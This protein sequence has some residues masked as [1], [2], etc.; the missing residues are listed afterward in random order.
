MGLK[1][2]AAGLLAAGCSTLLPAATLRVMTCNVRLPSKND[3]PNVWENRR[4][5]LVAAIRAKDPDLLGTQE[6]FQHQGDYIAAQAPEYSWFGLSRRGNHEDEHMGVF[7]K[8][9]KLRLLESGNFWLSETPETPGSMSW[10]VS[11][12]RMATWGLFEVRA[13][14]RRFY[15]YNTHFA[16]RRED[17]KARTLSARTIADRIAALP[18]NI[19]VVLTGDFNTGA[20]SEAYR[21]F[22]PLL[23]EVWAAAP[24]R[25]GPADTFH[26]FTGKPRPGRI[27]WIWYRGLRARR[28]ETV[29]FNRDGRYP[30]DHFPVFAELEFGR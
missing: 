19:P 27:D 29:I 8:K 23:M 9:E 1:F 24:D 6:L 3:G 4:D 16:H 18:H 13:T 22:E 30:S 5:L 10:D 15:Y 28:A 26:G 25:S 17:E 14:G 20:D 2:L 7:Y 21:I 11:L 12:P